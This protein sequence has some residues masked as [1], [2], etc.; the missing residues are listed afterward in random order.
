MDRR[1]FKAVLSGAIGGTAST[2]IHSTGQAIT[3]AAR[4]R[5]TDVLDHQGLN[6]RINLDAHRTAENLLPT[7]DLGTR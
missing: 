1:T 4:P 5:V 7:G 6:T 3:A 2:F